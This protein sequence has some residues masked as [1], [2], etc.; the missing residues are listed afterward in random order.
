[1]ALLDGKYVENKTINSKKHIYI[2]KFRS[3][4]PP[5]LIDKDMCG[6]YLCSCGCHLWTQGD[7]FKHWNEGHMDQL[8][9]KKL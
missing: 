2:G 4:E 9:Y 6:V 7:I 1:M 5:Y 3:P 8:C